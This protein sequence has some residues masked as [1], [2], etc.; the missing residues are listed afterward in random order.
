MVAVVDSGHLKVTTHVTGRQ[1]VDLK[2][3][4]LVFPRFKINRF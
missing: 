2:I 1:F 3:S 4:L